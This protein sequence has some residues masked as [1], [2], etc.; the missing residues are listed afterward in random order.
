MMSLGRVGFFCY[1][2][3]SSIFLVHLFGSLTDS[4]VWVFLGDGVKYQ[5][6]NR[7]ACA[8]A[9]LYVLGYCMNCSTKLFTDG[10]A[11][12]A[13]SIWLGLSHRISAIS[14]R[15]FNSSKLLIWQM[16]ARSRVR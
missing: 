7:A 16:K 11:N 2:Y 13:G 1:C 12:L 10:K 5:C 9:L 3:F 14:S 4:A 8:A 6:I 15:G